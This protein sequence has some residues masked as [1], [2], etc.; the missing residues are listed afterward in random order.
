MVWTVERDHPEFGDREPELRGNHG[1][2][3]LVCSADLIHKTGFQL[4]EG[5][6]A[7]ETPRDSKD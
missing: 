3:R 2:P 5:R 6:I 7:R 1:E 4:V